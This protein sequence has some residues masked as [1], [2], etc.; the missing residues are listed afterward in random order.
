M[1]EI[2]SQGCDAYAR[3]GGSVIWVY[4]DRISTGDGV[5]DWDLLETQLDCAANLDKS[6]MLQLTFYGSMTNDSGWHHYDLTP[7]WIYDTVPTE[8]N[9]ETGHHTGYVIA[10]LWAST[11][12]TPSAS[13]WRV[14]VVYAVGDVVSYRGNRYTCLEDH[15]SNSGANPHFASGAKHDL[16][17]YDNKAWRGKIYKIIKDFGARYSDDPRIDAIGIA[18]GFEG[19]THWMKNVNY[20]QWA[21]ALSHGQGHAWGTKFLGNIINIYHDAFAGTEQV[22]L[23]M[24]PGSSNAHKAWTRLYCL[25]KSPPIG[26]KHNGL[27]PFSPDHSSQI[28]K[29]TYVTLWDIIE[30]DW[31]DDQGIWHPPAWTQLPIWTESVQGLF[32]RYQTYLLMLQGLKSHSNGIDLHGPLFD[33]D[34]PDQIYTWV[35]AHV[36]VTLSTTPSVFVVLRDNEYPNESGWDTGYHGNF[37]FWL[38]Q[39]DSI[40][41]GCTQRVWREDLPSGNIAQGACAGGWYTCLCS[42]EDC[43]DV[44]YNHQVRRTDEAS[45]NPNM[46]FDVADAYDQTDFIRMIYLDEGTD[47]FSLFYRDLSG[48]IQELKVTK[49]NTGHFVEH[50]FSPTNAEFV[51][52]IDG[53]EGVDFYLSSNGDGDEYV[54]LVE[55]GGHQTPMP[56]PTPIPTPTPKR[57]VIGTALRP[58]AVP[59]YTYIS[60]VN[61]ATASGSVTQVD[62]W[63]V[64]D[65]RDAQDVSVGTFSC[66]QGECTMRDSTYIGP[67]P[68]G[69][70]RSYDTDINVKAGDLIGLYWSPRTNSYLEAAWE[71]NTSWTAVEN[72]LSGQPFAVDT[73]NQLLSIQGFITTPKGADFVGPE[74][75]D[76]TST[77]NPGY[78]YISRD[79]PSERS[80]VLDHVCVW[81]AEGHQDAYR[82]KVGTFS[83]AGPDCTVRDST[84][85]GHVARGRKVCF[86][87][88]LDVEV[89]DYIGVYWGSTTYGYLEADFQSESMWELAGDNFNDD[90]E[91]YNNRN[92]VGSIRGYFTDRGNYGNVR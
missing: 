92:A 78:T 20:E 9:D 21:A 82:V 28:D 58:G 51:N 65:Y 45:G 14:G 75:T 80:G 35:A 84:I 13:G 73:G 64:G 25:G 11:T 89:G 43:L 69:A 1:G 55:V 3:G 70:R 41:T 54:H 86:D 91:T 59:G 8:Y 6:V 30:K 62:V 32:G 68:S 81:F 61:E 31:P 29:E 40:P 53:T 47:T 44:L 4:I 34:I 22:Y 52:E 50:I 74:C 33:R 76:R 36:G 57:S 90:T 26:I 85:L 63:F 77:L 19:E 42:P 39:D 7:Q 71:A 5:Y 56:T 38:E 18:P 87:V 37:E 67:V 24:A 10:P 12:D 66:A 72:Q 23:N 48:Q 79:F 83:C 17:P 15:T 49:E 16:P 27:A 88:S 46:F 60:R 2:S